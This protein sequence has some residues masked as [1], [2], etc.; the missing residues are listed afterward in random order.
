MTILIIVV[1]ITLFVSANCSLYESV[2]YSTR[3]ATLEAARTKA[4][5]GRLASQFITLKKNISQP[6]AAILILN[7]VANTAGAT[8]AGMYA[9]EVLGAPLV[10]V[11]SLVL[12][13]GILF[14]SE[15]IPKTYGAVH[16]RAL[17]PFIVYP[18]SFMKMI[19]SPA[20]LVTEKI[21]SLITRKNKVATITEEEI[22]AL[23][24]LG[25]REGEIT[26]DESRMVRNIIDLEN[27]NVQ[28]IMTP[29]KMIF[30]L[31]VEMTIEEAF[32]KVSGRGITRIPIYEGDKENITGYVV[33][34]DLSDYKMSNK[35]EGSLQTI[36]RPI[37]HVSDKTNC[38]SM[39]TNFLKQ[40]KHIAIVSDEF[41][42]VDGLVTMEDLLET[43]LGS[44]IVDETD[45]IID[46]QEAARK[47]KSD[48]MTREK[49]DNS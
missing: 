36:M 19:L 17:W 10:P 13:L 8:I 27:H 41:G 28:E 43:L 3:P 18:L 4:K 9:T 42:G 26:K 2:L 34:H 15:I 30:S 22:L 31:P 7:T 21:T 37:S 39:L 5:R 48:N 6:I 25:A 29:R 1:F 49:G 45:Q 20:I 46:L 44:E 47:R 11:F 38:L 14:L 35:T 16:W 40:R 33:R 23:V 32:K 24:H 12:T